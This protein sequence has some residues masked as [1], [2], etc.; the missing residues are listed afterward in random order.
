ML[1]VTLIRHGES[2]HN[3]LALW[4]GCTECPLTERGM[5]QARAV[6][7]Y[8]ADTEF[9]KIYASPLPRARDTAKAVLDAQSTPKPPH[10]FTI[11]QIR[12][13]SFGAAEGHQTCIREPGKTLEAH[14]AEEKYPILY[15]SERH[16]AFPGGESVEDLTRRGE[17]AVRDVVLPHVVNVARSGR[18]EHIA[19]V[20][21]GLC[22]AQVV[23]AIVRL[24][25][26]TWKRKGPMVNTAWV[27]VEMR[28]QG[29]IPVEVADDE[30]PPVEVTVTEEGRADHLEGL[31]DEG[32]L[33]GMKAVM[34]GGAVD[35]K[36]S[37]DA[38]ATSTAQTSA[39]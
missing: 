35:A 13:Q 22:I 37:S 12:E 24:G 25:G 18:D 39:S 30:V 16:V 38:G 33:C 8:F 2:T 14:F 19:L 20:S 32:P 15:E 1:T 23:G 31:L 7:A 26:G 11:A 21:H 34:G 9:T 27:R 10:D 36:S 5:Q 29:G 3:V 17:R 4:S 6:G 28:I